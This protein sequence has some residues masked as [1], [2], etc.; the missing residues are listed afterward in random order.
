MGFNYKDEL[1]FT[2]RTLYLPP[3][4]KINLIHEESFATLAEA[5]A[6]EPKLSDLYDRKYRGVVSGYKIK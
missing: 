3:R 2:R 4:K 1:Q 5:L 6:Y